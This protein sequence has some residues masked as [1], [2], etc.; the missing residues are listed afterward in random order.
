MVVWGGTNGTEFFNT[1]GRYDPV[2]DSWTPTSTVGAPLGRD[3]HSAVWTG[4][5]M[6]VW[7]GE[8]SSSALYVN[9]GG[10]Y[11][12]STDTWTPTSTTG[13]PLARYAHTAVWTGSSM[14]I[15]G[16][17]A[18]AGNYLDTGGRYDPAAD[19][20]TP[21]ATVGAPTARQLHTAVWT[22]SLMVVW[23]GYGGGSPPDLNTGGRYDPATDS[24]TPT[25]T[26]GAPTG[27]RYHTA[28]W[29][30]SLMVVWG[31]TNGSEFFNT[32][33]RYDPVTDTWTPTAAEGAPSGRQ[34]FTAVWTGNLM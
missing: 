1:G 25:S 31:G 22:G 12:P 24:W 30:G 19:S 17:I 20:W 10:C 32:G 4:K 27:R 9:T 21:T 29:T 15:W 11:D 16:G 23:G 33:G 8:V 3:G 2:T 34:V 28:V 5:L 6:V 7:G 18:G 26:T 14:V 13:A